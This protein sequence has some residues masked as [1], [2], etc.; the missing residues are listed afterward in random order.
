MHTVCLTKLIY[1]RVYSVVDFPL[2]VIMLVCENAL[3]NIQKL[4]P[5]L[6]RCLR[7]IQQASAQVTLKG[8][9][10]ILYTKLSVK[11]FV[12]NVS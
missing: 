11:H 12:A 8:S 1:N 2:T 7:T 10:I 9:V 6:Q 3:V 5:S 4:C